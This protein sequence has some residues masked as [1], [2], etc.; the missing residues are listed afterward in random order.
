MLQTIYGELG[1]L[2][3][4]EGSFDFSRLG[5]SVYFLLGHD[6]ELASKSFCSGGVATQ[7]LCEARIEISG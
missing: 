2:L 1:I 4:F 5:Q 7:M 6:F 3:S